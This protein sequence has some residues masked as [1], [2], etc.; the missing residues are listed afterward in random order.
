MVVGT[1]PRHPHFAGYIRHFSRK[2]DSRLDGSMTPQ[3]DLATTT[4]FTPFY[5]CQMSGAKRL[6][7]SKVALSPTRESLF[8]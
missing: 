3:T 4:N 2:C 6:F 5:F 7:S 1:L 8:S